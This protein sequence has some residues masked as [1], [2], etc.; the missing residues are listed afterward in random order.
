MAIINGEENI[1]L[2]FVSPYLFYLRHHPQSFP[3]QFMS[4]PVMPWQPRHFTKVL[5]EKRDSAGVEV[6]WGRRRGRGVE[7]I[8]WGKSQIGLHVCYFPFDD[9][10]YFTDVDIISAMS[11]VLLNQDLNQFKA[12]I[13]SI[14]EGMPTKRLWQEH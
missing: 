14:F 8:H 13:G 10:T 4:V 7:M 3:G 6:D 12:R 9:T 11:C 1:I 2:L 5:P